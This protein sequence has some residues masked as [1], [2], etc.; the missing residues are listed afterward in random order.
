M[1]DLF[2]RC[3][4]Q[5]LA[6]NSKLSQLLGTAYNN[7]CEDWSAG[8]PLIESNQIFL[9]P[10]HETHRY[11]GPGKGG[12][13]L[14]DLEWTATVSAAVRIY[15]YTPDHGNVGRGRGPTALIASMRAIVDSFGETE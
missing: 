1:S 11:F 10:P 7:Y 9:Q 2:D 6:L 14:Q 12:D 13:W 4:L 5:G 15:P 8:G 3:K